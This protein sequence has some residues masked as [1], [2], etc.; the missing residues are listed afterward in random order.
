MRVRRALHC[1]Y[2]STMTTAGPVL[3]WIRAFHVF[4]TTAVLEFHLSTKTFSLKYSDSTPRLRRST[5]SCKSIQSPSH[6]L[7]RPF[8]TKVCESY[9]HPLIVH[10]DSSIWRKPRLKEIFVFAVLSP[11]RTKILPDIRI[12]ILTVVRL[13]VIGGRRKNKRSK[14]VSN[15]ATGLCIYVA[16]LSTISWPIEGRFLPQITDLKKAILRI[17]K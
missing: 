2:F 4:L 17:P 8:C 16:P 9:E 6:F 15:A 3:Q 12:E 10:V 11:S 1:L 7:S 14:K 13:W 5:F